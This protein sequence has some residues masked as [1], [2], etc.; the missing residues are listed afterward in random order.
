MLS[1]R[2]GLPTAKPLLWS[3]C[4]SD[5]FTTLWDHYRLDLTVEAHVLDDEFTSLFADGDRQRALDR[6]AQYGWTKNRPE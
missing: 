4:P 5:G 1:E 2:G 3:D 6:L